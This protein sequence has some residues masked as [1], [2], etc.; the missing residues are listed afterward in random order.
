MIKRS[1]RLTDLPS[2]SA[3]TIE[4]E[5]LTKDTEYGEMADRGNAKRVSF[6]TETEDTEGILRVAKVRHDSFRCPT[7]F[8][9]DGTLCSENSVF[10]RAFRY[11]RTYRTLK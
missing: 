7:C 11:V 8:W 1:N 9:G 6:V 10:G 2:K 5:L 4:S 3:G